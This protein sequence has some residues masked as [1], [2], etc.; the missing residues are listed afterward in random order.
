MQYAVLRST[1]I[2]AGH[3]PCSS[4]RGFK[5]QKQKQNT[6][7]TAKMHKEKRGRDRKQE[8]A[9]PVGQQQKPKGD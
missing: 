3:R 1:Q 5:T 8:K 7:N 9:R 4:A 2:T 6:Q